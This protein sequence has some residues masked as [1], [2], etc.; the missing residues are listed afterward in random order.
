MSNAKVKPVLWK[1]I[2]LIFH[3]FPKKIKKLKIVPIKFA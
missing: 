1:T 3:T 2:E